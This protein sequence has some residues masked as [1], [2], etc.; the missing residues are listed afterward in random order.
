MTMA[1][2][3]REQYQHLLGLQYLHMTAEKEARL[4]GLSIMRGRSL[5]LVSELEIFSASHFPDNLSAVIDIDDETK[6]CLKEKDNQHFIKSNKT[7]QVLVPGKLL[8][9]RETDIT[10]TY[11]E[12]YGKRI[13]VSGPA[14]VRTSK[15]LSQVVKYT[16]LNFYQDLSTIVHQH[17]LQRPLIV[18]NKNPL[19][20]VGFLE[21]PKLSWFDKK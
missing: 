11:I 5:G 8:Q 1:K 17:E 4:L 9:R 16:A 6:Y 15:T 13:P 19:V 14:I 21:N 12:M 3:I 2:T 18:M 20:Y 7:E 10:P